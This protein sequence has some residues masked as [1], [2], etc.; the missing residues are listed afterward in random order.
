MKLWRYGRAIEILGNRYRLEGFLGS[1]GMAE[2]C[3]AWDKHEQR[4]VA[5]KILK[6]EE[7]D[8]KMLNRFLKEA[9]QIV[10]WQ[11]P[12]ILRMYD[13][14]QIDVIEQEDKDAMLLYLVMEY[15]NGGS[16]Q[17]RLTLGEPYSLSA[18]FTL[19]RQ[20]CGAVAYAHK[21]DVIHR[22]IK[23]SSSQ[24]R[25]T[26]SPSGR[27]VPSHLRAGRHVC[28]HG[29]GAVTWS[30]TTRQRYFCTGCHPLSTLHGLS[31]LPAGNAASYSGA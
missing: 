17:D 11:H 31:A 30:G 20:I 23:P 8:R 2:V 29:P 5:V 9:G 21:H 19:F 15:A 28:L 24:L 10:G 25:N 1:G 26:E 7:L 13:H 22:D 16:L 4:Q 27:C 6:T 12:H 18:T 3:L 14:M